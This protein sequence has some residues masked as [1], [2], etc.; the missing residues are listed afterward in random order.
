MS[1]S[2]LHFG[3]ICALGWLHCTI[4]P[5]SLRTLHF[6]SILSLISI[7]KSGTFILGRLH[8]FTDYWTEYVAPHFLIWLQSHQIDFS[9][10]L[11]VSRSGSSPRALSLKR[12]LLPYLGQYIYIWLRYIIA[13][14]PHPLHL[15]LCITAW[16]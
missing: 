1:K 3:R 14:H 10:C 6:Q 7:I 11:Q 15:I 5:S 8:W 13:M 12:L 2:Q 9:S 16:N 4:Q